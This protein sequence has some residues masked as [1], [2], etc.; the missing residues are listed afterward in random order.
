MFGLLYWVPLA[1]TD[2]TK[3]AMSAG[4]LC[5]SLLGM[6]SSTKRCWSLMVIQVE[7]RLFGNIKASIFH[8]T[9][10]ELEIQTD[11]QLNHGEKE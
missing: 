6:G 3:G 1:M 10:E 5:F 8:E 4:L 9:H 11:R 7:I 2:R